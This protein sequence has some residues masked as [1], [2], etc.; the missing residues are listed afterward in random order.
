MLAATTKSR[1]G[2]F[3]WAKYPDITQM[4]Y[5]SFP[6]IFFQLQ[7]GQIC[8]WF[9]IKHVKHVKWRLGHM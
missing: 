7:I 5:L 2:G 3:L 1:G 9:L 4:N 6:K 8:I